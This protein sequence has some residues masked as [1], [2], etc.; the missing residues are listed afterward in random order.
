MLQRFKTSLAQNQGGS[1]NT[2]LIPFIFVILLLIGATSFGVWAFSSREDY[3]NNTD[4]KI[5]VAVTSAKQQQTAADAVTYAQEAKDPLDTYIGPAAYGSINVLYPKTWSAY[6]ATASQTGS[7]TPVNGYFQPS[8]VPDVTNSTNTYALR[9]EVTQTAYSEVLDTF[10]G[11]VQQGTVTV[12]PYS[13]PKVPSVVGVKVTGAIEQNKQG[14]MVILPLR[15][16]TLQVWTESTAEE[17]D[18]NNII[19]PNLSFSP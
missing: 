19:L 8:V 6:V 9:V 3:K 1:L 16:N 12:T 18:L 5:G 11:L 17:S 15:A 2:L 4:Q 10:N 14:V 7:S 13:L